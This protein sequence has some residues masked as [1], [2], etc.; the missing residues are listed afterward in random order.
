MPHRPGHCQAD[1]LLLG[2]ISHQDADAWNA[3]G[4]LRNSDEWRA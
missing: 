1:A 4:L 3:C 2:K